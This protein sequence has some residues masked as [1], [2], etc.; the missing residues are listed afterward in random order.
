MKN[1]ILSAALLVALAVP[2]PSKAEPIRTGGYMSG[3]IGVGIPINA[4]VTTE[5]FSS[6]NVYNDRVEYDPGVNLGL[7]GGY[8]FGY[9]RLEG[10]LA[11]KGSEVAEITDKADG[12]H[13]R[14]P[15]GD[16]SVYAMM[17]NGFADLRNSTTV[18][19]Y[20]GGGIGFASLYL[21]DTF[22]TDTRG[23]FTTRDLLYAEDVDTVFAYQVGGGLEI[24]LNS[25]VSL[26]LSYRY[27]GTAKARFDDDWNNMTALKYKSHNA[28][29]GL[30][31]KF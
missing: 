9:F 14:N 24:A 18:T 10:E 8:N 1:I 19:P 13:Y 6:G 28:G 22:G 2:A 15:D 25:I 3:Y 5:V 11:Y 7:T 23:G 29:L 20:F 31:I 27:F 21:S 30:R 4:D 26:D 17:F 16:I 12:Y